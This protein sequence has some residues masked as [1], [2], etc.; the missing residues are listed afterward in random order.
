MLADEDW[1]V[2]CVECGKP[3]PIQRRPGG[4]INRQKRLCSTACRS[5]FRQDRAPKTFDGGTRVFHKK[6]G[7]VWI[8]IPAYLSRT[9]KKM[10]MLHH[11]YVMEQHLDRELLRHEVIHHLNGD[12]TD[13]RIENLELFTTHH[14]EGARV[15]DKVSHAIDILRLYPEI[16]RKQGVMLVSV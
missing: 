1:Q 14:G 5:K 10:Q 16:A 9:G 11:R 2:N 12:K 15:T 13:N 4:T 8:S 6:R 3:M 7:Y